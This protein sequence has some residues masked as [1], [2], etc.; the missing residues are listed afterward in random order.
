MYIVTKTDINRKVSYAVICNSL[1][2]A[3]VEQVDH[4]GIILKATEEK[5]SE[6]ETNTITRTP[7]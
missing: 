2:A 6:K 7:S 1:A 4:G 3:K 5:Q